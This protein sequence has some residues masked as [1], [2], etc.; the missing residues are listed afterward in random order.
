MADA[1]KGDDRPTPRVVSRRPQRICRVS[2]LYDG[3]GRSFSVEI[4]GRKCTIILVR[5]NTHIFAYA[6]RCPHM[7]ISLLWDRK[8]LMTAD[9]NCIRCANHDAHFQIAEGICISGPCEGESLK[10]L[11]IKISRGSV[12]LLPDDSAT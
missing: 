10:S 12:W 4:D 6:D 2:E 8:V 7:E 1:Q 9:G 3:E 11:M 5:R